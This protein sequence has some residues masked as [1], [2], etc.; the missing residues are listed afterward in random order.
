MLRNYILCNSV[1]D[2]YEV[3]YSWVP[4]VSY[5]INT[6]FLLFA[7]KFGSGPGKLHSVTVQEAERYCSDSVIKDVCCIECQHVL[8][9]CMLLW[10]EGGGGC[11]PLPNSRSRQMAC[12]LCDSSSVAKYNYV[13]ALLKTASLYCILVYSQLCNLLLIC[14]I[15][16]CIGCIWKLFQIIMCLCCFCLSM[17]VYVHYVAYLSA[18]I[19]TVR[20]AWLPWWM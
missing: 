10:S 11:F 16:R 9:N 2:L 1:D 3:L 12:V 6:F 13:F 5:K 20:P 7:S 18:V 8:F 19:V 4:L 17:C 15:L 14:W